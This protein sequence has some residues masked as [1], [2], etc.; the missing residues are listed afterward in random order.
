M[1]EVIN[2]MSNRYEAVVIFD[3]ALSEQDIQQQVEK[4]ETAIKSHAGVLEKHDV[5]GRRELAYKIKKKDYGIYVVFIFSGDNTLVS[6]LKRQL[7][8][9]DAVL[10]S[11]IVNKDQ[12]APDALHPPAVETTSSYQ[13]GY[14]DRRSDDRDFGGSY[15]DGDDSSAM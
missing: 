3:S 6:D 8:I 12:Y 5:W 1:R 10:R 11:L 13:G 7:R 4:I 15:M 9:N 14:R 2:R